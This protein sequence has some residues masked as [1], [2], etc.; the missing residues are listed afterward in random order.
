MIDSELAQKLIELK[1]Y[2]EQYDLAIV[3]MRTAKTQQETVEHWRRSRELEAKYLSVCDWIT[4]HGYAPTW[5]KEEQ[6]Y[7]VRRC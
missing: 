3:L 4:A 5:N 1:V 6:C 7:E 2:A